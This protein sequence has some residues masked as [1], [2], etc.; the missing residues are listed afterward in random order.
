MSVELVLR[1]PRRLW[2]A[3]KRRAEAEGLSIEEVVVLALAR[4]LEEEAR[5]GGGG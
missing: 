2:E 4:L 1:V 5:A 3:L